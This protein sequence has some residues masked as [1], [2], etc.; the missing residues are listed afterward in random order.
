MSDGDWGENFLPVSL[1]DISVLDSDGGE[2]GI[3]TLEGLA[4]L[5]DFKS[6]AFDHSATS[7]ED[8]GRHYTV[9]FCGEN[10]VL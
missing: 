10:R 1:P 4:P 6:A 8:N 5:T 9:P 7:P 2:E 3:R